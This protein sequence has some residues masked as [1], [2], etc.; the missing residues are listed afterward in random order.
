MSDTFGDLVDRTMRDWLY[1][2]DD[3]P[4]RMALSSPISQTD[5][6]LTYDP[7]AMLP[8]QELLLG[9]GTLIELGQEQMLVGEVNA[10]A[11]T[12]TGL[13]R[14]VNGTD[15][16]THAANT[17]ILITP[18]FSRRSVADALSSAIVGL[19]PR[20]YRRRAISLTLQTGYTE[21]PEDAEIP[22]SFVW[23]DGAYPQFPRIRLVDLPTLS[24]GRALLCL[25]ASTGTTGTLVYR[26]P[27]S[28]PDSESSVLHAELGVAPGLEAAVEV[29][30]V[31]HLVAS[32]D[33]DALT[34]EFLTRQF[35]AQAN[36]TGTTGTRLREALLRYYEYLIAELT[37]HVEVVQFHNGWT[38]GA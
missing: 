31:A 3:Q 28:A 35:E 4:T 38:R 21:V 1:P 5:T 6:S 13:V 32:R 22:E 12:V 2:P 24:T 27:F 20:L 23:F 34:V 33:L 37:R 9:P 18:T 19:Y 26:G 29:R 16:S 25:D 11:N 36:Q 17:D 14:G 30:A 10:D 8:E 7:A 15:R